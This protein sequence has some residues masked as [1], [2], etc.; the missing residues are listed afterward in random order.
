[1][2]DF[3]ATFVMSVDLL[4]YMFDSTKISVF[5]DTH[6]CLNTFMYQALAFLESKNAAEIREHITLVDMNKN[7]NFATIYDEMENK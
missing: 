3:I 6:K 4:F 2:S 1:M 5:S 7:R